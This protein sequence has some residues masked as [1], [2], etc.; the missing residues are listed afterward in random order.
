LQLRAA[1]SL[2]RLLQAQGR[3]EEARLLLGASYS[4]FTEGYDTADL[5]DARDLLEELA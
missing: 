4:W 1:K 3:R 2:S 5:Q